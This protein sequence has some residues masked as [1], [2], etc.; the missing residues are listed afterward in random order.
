MCDG[1]RCVANIVQPTIDTPASISIRGEVA[2]KRK[3]IIS[4]RLAYWI[5]LYRAR[6]KDGEAIEQMSDKMAY[7]V[8]NCG[9]IAL[10]SD[11][12]IKTSPG[13][14]HQNIQHGAVGNTIEFY[15][16]MRSP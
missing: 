10:F 14:Q 15:L 3:R 1:F 11:R 9:K 4:S 5:A 13:N 7:S 12:C 6:Q 16:N 8:K 2:K